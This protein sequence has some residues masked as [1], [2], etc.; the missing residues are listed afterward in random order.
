MS[1]QPI[2]IREAVDEVNRTW[3][4]PA[5]QRPYDWGERNRKEEFIYKLF[6]SIMREYPI[7]TLI[8]WRTNEKIPYRHFA[9]DYDC[10]K[11]ERIVDKRL[12]G[13][14]DKHLI[15]DGQQRLQS[16]YSCLKFTFHGDILCYDLLFSRAKEPE[17]KGFR[18]VPKNDEL[19]PGHIGVNEVY[20]YNRREQAEFEDKILERLRE[21]KKD[22]TKKEELTAKSN[23]KQLWKLFVERNVKLLSYYDLQRDMEQTEVL[24]IF[25]RIN[26]TGM[27]LTKTEILFA[28]IKRIRYDFEEQIWDA[29]LQIKAQTGNGFSFG[30]DNMLRVLNLIVKNTVRVDPQRVDRSELQEYVSK[31]SD[32]KSPMTSFFYD[33]LF[34]EFKITH[35]KIIPYKR[36]MIPIIAYFYYMRTVN[37]RKFKDFSSNSIVNMK[38]YLIF[39]QLLSW[40]LQGYLD[41][42]H[43]RIKAVCDA[44]GKCD[45]PFVE[46]RKFVKDRGAR[47]YDLGIEDFNRYSDPWFALKV[48]MPNRQY[49]FLTDPDERFN[50]EI[51]HIFPEAPDSQ[52]S[53]ATTYYQW[54]STVWNL[55]PVKGEINNFKLAQ[56]PK[57]FFL[58]HRVYMKDYD[59]LPCKDLNDKRWL[60]QH[61]DVFI[62]DRK[63]R[64]VAFVRQNYGIDLE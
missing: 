47:R 7:G 3:F 42:F 48:L 13:K 54:V 15:Y 30:P 5:I 8:I 39:S 32:L 9:E 6:D 4:I 2:S 25:K 26:S 51:D 22:L 10:E 45:F 62:Q 64:M 14:K 33:F 52:P 44:G 55:Q 11:L 20:S 53:E 29:N 43:R 38:K 40:D 24:D 56:M 37:Q 58:R 63:K 61:A 31:W 19:E 59:F 1:Y 41:E 60:P 50:P 17:S 28:E 21:S 36:A 12:W 35:E 27:V 18:F 57:D 49:S 46:L 34:H 23:L 16:L